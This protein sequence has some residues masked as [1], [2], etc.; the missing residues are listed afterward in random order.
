MDRFARMAAFLDKLGRDIY[1]EPAMPG[2]DDLNRAMVR[3]V[4]ERF[5]QRAG[6][7]VLDL[8]CGRGAA[9][10]EFRAAGLDPLGITMGDDADYCRAHGLKV[11]EMNFAFLDLPDG[12]FEVAWCRHVLEHSVFP[13]FTLCEMNRLLAP[14]G[15]LYVEVPAPDTACRHQANRNHYSVL[16]HSMWRELIER[17]GFMVVE[18][19]DHEVAT[20]QGPDLYWSFLAQKLR[21]AA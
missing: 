2:A 6:A 1:P 8:G 17:A 18:E 15:I 13:Y 10:E 21:D 20:A 16:G 19:L 9:L 7:P 11:A 14:F 3:H 12:A 4:L 5:P